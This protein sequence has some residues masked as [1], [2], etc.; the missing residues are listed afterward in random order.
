VIACL[1]GFKD[2]AKKDNPFYFMP[3]RKIVHPDEDIRTMILATGSIKATADAFGY[4]EE[5]I[6]SLCHRRGWMTPA[7]ATKKRR[8]ADAAL[9]EV[10]EA[11]QKTSE[12]QSPANAGEALQKHLDQSSHTFRSSMATALSSAAVAASEMP[13]ISALDMS[14]KL[15]DLATAGKTIFQ[16]GE[17]SKGGSLQLNVLQLS[18][19]QLTPSV[20]EY[21]PAVVS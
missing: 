19:D 14:R 3:A 2:H 13:A 4:K 17:E 21:L 20:R 1:T 11:M 15:V 6:R 18:L 12:T 16:L 7:R 10:R 8:E 5:T 9:T